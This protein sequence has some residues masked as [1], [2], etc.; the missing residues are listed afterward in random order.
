MP[1]RL[2]G[3]LLQ[4]CCMWERDKGKNDICLIEKGTTQTN[5]EQEK[6]FVGPSHTPFMFTQ[7]KFHNLLSDAPVI[8]ILV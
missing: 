6:R 2:Q 8:L 5:S 4:I 1:R 7:D 3:H